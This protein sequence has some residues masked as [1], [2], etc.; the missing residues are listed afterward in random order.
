MRPRVLPAALVLAMLAGS[1]QASG[2]APSAEGEGEAEGEEQ[3]LD[4]GQAA[5]PGTMRRHG[6]I[7]RL[8]VP[9]GVNILDADILARMR[10]RLV[11][12]TQEHA[13]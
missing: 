6:V 2:P 7:G 10:D 3:Q 4:P 11:I 13:E 9:E 12:Y 8:T 5:L 1:L